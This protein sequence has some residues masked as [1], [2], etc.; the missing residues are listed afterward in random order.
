MP[1]ANLEEAFR[2]VNSGDTIAIKAGLYTGDAN[3][4]FK[5]DQIFLQQDGSPKPSMELTIKGVTGDPGD[6]V[7]DGQNNGRQ[8]FFIFQR[9]DPYNDK[10]RI[11]NITFQN[12]F[13][14]G[15]TNDG[16]AG[17]GAIAF[18]SAHTELVFE[19]VIFKKNT[20]HQPDYHSGGG[21]VMIQVAQGKKPPMFINCRFIDNLSLIHI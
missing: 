4:G 6:V 1:L 14:N 5:D 20:S 12:E 16:P 3:A 9:R 15:D 19:N 13:H 2:R 18:N 10:I 21:A 17:G 7:F 11:E 8:R